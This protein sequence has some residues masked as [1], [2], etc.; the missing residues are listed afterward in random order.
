[1]AH[2]CPL[3]DM[4]DVVLAHSPR[5]PINMRG[6]E[7]FEIISFRTSLSKTSKNLL[8]LSVLSSLLLFL[9][10]SPVFVRPGTI[11]FWFLFKLFSLLLINSADPPVFINN[12]VLVRVSD[13][14]CF[15]SL[16]FVQGGKGDGNGAGV[17]FNKFSRSLGRT[18]C[19]LSPKFSFAGRRGGWGH[20]S[21]SL[22]GVRGSSL[23][24]E[25][26]RP[27]SVWW[28]S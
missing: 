6:G 5:P 23:F 26:L 9:V 16:Q 4:R 8:L 21:L 12:R 1:M 28:C 14:P 10:P 20:H 15:A 17:N 13:T 18:R 7:D 3:S 24:E 19:G 11:F 25:L 2:P 27:I 22:G